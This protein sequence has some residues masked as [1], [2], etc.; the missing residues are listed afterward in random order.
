MDDREL[1]YTPA[2]EQAA[3]VRR[4]NASPTELAECYL[5]R[6]EALDPQI[7]SYLTVAADQAHEA[8]GAAER[9][10]TT[11]GNETADLPPFLGVPISIKDLNDTAGIRSTHGTA[12]WR[13]RVP[14][15]DDEVVARVRRAGFVILGKTVTPEFGPLNISEPPG[16]PPGRN[17]WDP[18]RTCG[19]SSGGAAAA[20]AAGLCAV[21]QGSDGG[22]S[23][24]N[25]SSWCGAFGIKPQR[26]RV[27]AAPSPQSFFSINGPIAR[28]VGDAA[29]LLD[30]LSG[31]ATG[32][33]WWAPPSARPLAQEVGVD[34]GRLRVAF[35]E[36]PGVERD[37][38]AAANRDAARATA[39]LLAELGHDVV[40]AVPPGYAEDILPQ[41]SVVFAANHAAEADLTPYPP[42]ETLDPW[43]RTLVE[44]GRL[45]SAPD[46]VKAMH[47]LQAL[48]RR[49]VA[50][51]DDYDVFVSPTVAG[52]PP[53]I[54][55]M[56]GAGMEDVA[57]FW[58]L[59][60]FTALWNTTGQPAL[61]VPLAH[62]D[63]GLPV[64][65]QIVGRPAD[66]ATLVRVAS[67]I[68]AAQ[69]WIGRRPP[70]S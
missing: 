25:P 69:P 1:A 13:D 49:T 35:H 60:P 27:P 63:L 41:S 36:H 26:G 18:E 44:M 53:P 46:Y 15:A 64:G 39:E 67:Q 56:A 45:V 61:S 48:S 40:E 30:V 3:M 50:F 17:P 37:A 23:I 43:M 38:C 14:D 20:L 11:A 6:I 10:L 59:T 31:P 70:V 24:R 33:A 7:S 2:V 12:E 68:E 8:A 21:S 51:F 58:A 5:R 32:D 34:P 19:G 55:S 9:I 22:G 65:V 52:P 47:D 54:G 16:Y 57:K 62:D 42:L 66:E 29:A 4:G 28:T